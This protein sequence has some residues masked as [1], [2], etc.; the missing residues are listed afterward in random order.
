MTIRKL[1][2]LLLVFAAGFVIYRLGSDD[3]AS[4]AQGGAL[5]DVQVPELGPLEKQGESAFNLTCAA[6]HGVN[7]VG[8]EG[9]GPPLVHRIYEPNHHADAA[10]VLAVRNGV[11]SHHWR[12]GDMPPVDGVTPEQLDAIIAY[13]R[14]LQRANGIFRDAG[15]KT[16]EGD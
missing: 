11:R 4:G 16:L 14:T 6:C 1:L 12:F 7:A 3:S 5:V 8:I 10:F 2:V 15:V 9:R 13:I